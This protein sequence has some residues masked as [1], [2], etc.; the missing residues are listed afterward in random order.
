MFMMPER[1]AK[2]R[3][4]VARDFYKPAISYLYDLG[5]MQINEMPQELN[6]LIKKNENA[7][8]AE[9]SKYSAKFKTLKST[10][11]Q[12]PLVKKYKFE[13]LKDL[14]EQADSVNIYDE[15][16]DI[17]KEIDRYNA[18]ISNDAK[19]KS[20]VQK[21]PN[22]D[23]DLSALN[24]NI[25]VS[26]AIFKNQSDKAYKVSLQ[27]FMGEL[28]SKLKDSIIVE[29]ENLYLLI[30]KR[31]E[32]SIFGKLAS[33]YKMAIE[34]I[35]HLK[36]SA[37][38]AIKDLDAGI[39]NAEEKIKLLQKSLNSMSDQYYNLV[40]ALDE[41]FDI[42]S[43]E[44]SILNKLGITK[45]IVILEG[46]IAK[47]N[48]SSLEKMLDKATFGKYIIQ[49]LKTDEVAPTKLRNNKHIKIFESF[50]K[51]YSLPQSNEVDPTFA[52]ALVFPIFFGLM[53]GDAGYGIV[54][55][56]LS[57]FLIKRAK[58]PSLAPK[59]ESKLSSFIHSIVSDNGLAM[60]AKGI[61]PGSVL[62]IILGIVFNEYFGFSMPFY[63]GFNLELN[64]SKMLVIAG[65]IGVLMVAAGMFFGFINALIVNNK[66]HAAGRIGWIL[67]EIGIVMAGLM[68]LHSGM[69]EL[70][71]TPAIIYY[72]LIVA[73]LGIVLYSEG[74][75]SII[76]LPSLISNV[77]SYMRLIGILLSTVILAAVIDQ[78]FL[79]S[80]SH[81]I[82]FAIVGVIILLIGQIFT[83][84]IAAFEPGIQGVRLM[85]VEFFSGFFKGNGMPFKPYHGKRVH[86]IGLI[87]EMNEKLEED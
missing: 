79:K 31:S 82:L 3:I 46:W 68:L 74:S 58:K 54:L 41:Q 12:R 70:S 22:L 2:I 21:L 76:E 15:A 27:K 32:E 57:L 38:E 56:L 64:L 75:G 60:I 55:L 9:I 6:T 52:F 11:Y 87:G 42:E 10:L 84:V 28:K 40:A 86:T 39:K 1:M 4:I 23:I 51:F 49:V 77:L 33:N 17:T 66:K 45:Y 80:L 83:I 65:W 73:G 5:V 53:V 63:Q 18:A 69:T 78:I 20:L 8:Y 13:S 50:V 85:Y 35:P 30:I 16:L 43:Q 62:A 14:I 44:L 19:A 36:G 81:S 25:I 26:Y 37:E 67:I 47:K 48:I 71:T 59:K 24:T 7:S 34:V 29:N 61:L 72:I